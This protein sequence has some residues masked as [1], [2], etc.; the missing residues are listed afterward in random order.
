MA[1]GLYTTFGEIE[2]SNSMTELWILDSENVFC[3]MPLF[4]DF[5]NALRSTNLLSMAHGLLTNFSELKRSNSK[6][7]YELWI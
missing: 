3:F 6:K 7:K 4:R 5:Q 2:R 1:H